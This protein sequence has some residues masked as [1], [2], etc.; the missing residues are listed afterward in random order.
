MTLKKQSIIFDIFIPRH[1]FIFE[2]LEFF[3]FYFTYNIS[4][5]FKLVILL[6]SQNSSKLMFVPHS[7][8]EMFVLSPIYITMF[9]INVLHFFTLKFVR[10]FFVII[11]LQTLFAKVSY[12]LPY[13]F[14]FFL[15]RYA[16]IYAL[17]KTELVSKQILQIYPLLNNKT[18]IKNKQI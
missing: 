17:V 1:F 6:F 2:I 15:R 13:F 8:S 7:F 16:N 10:V 14:K 3:T 12:F 5:L 4:F 9:V 18:D 11:L